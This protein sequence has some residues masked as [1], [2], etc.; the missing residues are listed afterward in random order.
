MKLFNN[1]N[2]WAAGVAFAAQLAAQ[3]GYSYDTLNRLTRV[4]YSDGTVIVYA[5]DSAGNRLSQVIA[6]PSI[7][8]P[9][10]SVDKSA[11]TFS[12]A[13]G[14]AAQAQIISVTNSGG[15]SLQWDAAATAPWIS[16]TP[17]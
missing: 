4:A 1:L 17:G 5:Y 9:K 7:P 14:L 11:L 15:G 8:L 13:A 3:T 6:N 12:A 16:V 2:L 10:V